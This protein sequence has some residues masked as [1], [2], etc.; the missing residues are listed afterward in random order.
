MPAFVDQPA[1]P[2]LANFVDAVRELVAAILDMN[3]SLAVR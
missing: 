2:H 1:S 3:R